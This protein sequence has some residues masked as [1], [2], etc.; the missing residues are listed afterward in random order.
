MLYELLFPLADEFGGFRLI[1]FLTFRT[2]GSVITALLLSFILGPAIISWL[3]ARQGAGQPI[4]DDGP[5]NH[6]KK[7][8]TPTMGGA[9]ILLALVFST[10]LWAKLDNKLLWAVLIVTV[11]FGLIGAIDDY[12]KLV[13]RSTGGLSGRFKLLGQFAISIAVVLW[14]TLP[15]GTGFA[16]SMAC[17]CWKMLH[18]QRSWINITPIRQVHTPGSRC[19]ERRGCSTAGWPS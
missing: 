10:L 19:S 13:Q 2:G 16:T 18:K 7:I 8:G 17:P 4:R 11:G 6:L 1:G 5:E 15:E 9:L 12:L 3:K 14:L